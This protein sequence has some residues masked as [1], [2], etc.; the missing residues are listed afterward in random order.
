[1]ANRKVKLSPNKA[2]D[3]DDL[4]YNETTATDVKE[5]NDELA[6]NDLMQTIEFITHE[7]LDKIVDEQDYT[8]NLWHGTTLDGINNDEE[9][10]GYDLS[11]VVNGRPMPVTRLSMHIV[12]DE[13]NGLQTLTL[14]AGDRFNFRKAQYVLTDKQREMLDSRM[15]EYNKQF[16]KDIALKKARLAMKSKLLK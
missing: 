2:D 13:A 10:L 6:V 16:T 1:M 15:K 4:K 12:K 7:W 9:D 11:K 14:D 5:N 3:M 8:F